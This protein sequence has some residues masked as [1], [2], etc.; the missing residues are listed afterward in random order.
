MNENDIIK[1]EIILKYIPNYI[2]ESIQ[3]IVLSNLKKNFY[4][5]LRL[6]QSKNF[7]AEEKF[8][9][10]EALL[11]RLERTFIPPGTAIGVLASQSIGERQTQLCLDSFHSSGLSLST[12]TTGVPRFLQL[13][14]C[15]K[16]AKGSTCSFRLKDGHTS[17]YQIQKT[18]GSSLREIKFKDI[19]NSY[20]ISFTTEKKAWYDIY[21]Y[22]FPSP[23]SCLRKKYITLSYSLKK[24]ALYRNHLSL[25]YIQEKLKNEIK[26]VQILVSP[27]QLGQIDI[28]IDYEIFNN[29]L[30]DTNE[31]KKFN[32]EDLSYINSNLNLF[33]KIFYINVLKPKIEDIHISGIDRIV[34]Y[35]IDKMGSNEY[36]ISTVGT[37]IENILKLNFI[38]ENSLKSTDMW[39]VYNL[40]GIEAARKF[41]MEELL[42]VV[43]S[44]GNFINTCHVSLLAD[45][46]TYSGTLNSISRYGIKKESKSIL[47]KST[48]EESLDHFKKA[49]LFS[50]QENINS[51]SSCIMTGKH[52]KV[53]SGL[54]DIT[55]DW[56]K[57]S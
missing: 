12:T 39:G 31:K 40:L 20:E 50:E 29:Y 17:I 43:S 46:M 6:V 13:I 33:I 4:T 15:S 57:F 7:T 34:D 51:I 10:Q 49:S 23:K 3:S 42:Q 11:K 55:I 37:N 44:D 32:I 53:G 27:L 24:E 52:S 41:L 56:N 22:F 36:K 18:I 16:E 1:D 5:K 2:D 19:I 54:C 47:S 48:F 14:N 25:S 35:Y 21:E 38:D 30:N 45:S 8:A 26:N 28:L 9:I